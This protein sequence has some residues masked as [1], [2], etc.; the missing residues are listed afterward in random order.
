MAILEYETQNYYRVDF[1]RSFIQNSMVFA[2]IVIY[3][4]ETDRQIEKSRA[5]EFQA[6]DENSKNKLL[7]L[8]GSEQNADICEKFAK[9][10]D[11]VIRMRYLKNGSG[12]SAF[13]CDAETISL[14]SDCGFK[15]EWINQPIHITATKIVNCGLHTGEAFTAEYIY[16]KLKSKMSSNVVNI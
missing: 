13:M 12:T 16:D 1:E 15:Q 6:F 7:S 10:V 8:S 4:S 5:A 14:L 2:S 11:S 9:A 3:A